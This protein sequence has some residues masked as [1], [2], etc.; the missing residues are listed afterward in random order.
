MN[1]ST[2]VENMALKRDKILL[3]DEVANLNAKVL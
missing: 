2:E 3:S 1:D